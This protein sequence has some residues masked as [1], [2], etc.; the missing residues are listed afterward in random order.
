[1]SF[2]VD[3]DNFGCYCVTQAARPPAVFFCAGGHTTTAKQNCLNR[4]RDTHTKSQRSFVTRHRLSCEE[5][6]RN[7]I[8][9]LLSHA[10]EPR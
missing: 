10:V 4:C 5:H 1:M 8:L 3:I 6:T 7:V 9:G 2:G